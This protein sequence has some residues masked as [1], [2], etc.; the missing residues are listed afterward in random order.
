MPHSSPAA[1]P[2][3]SLSDQWA[4]TTSFRRLR[5][6]SWGCLSLFCLG[7]CGSVAGRH[8]APIRWA[9][10]ISLSLDL[11]SEGGRGG[12][13]RDNAQV[14]TTATTAH[15]VTQCPGTGMSSTTLCFWL[16]GGTTHAPHPDPERRDQGHRLP[17]A[18]TSH[19]S[20]RRESTVIP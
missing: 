19:K 18:A 16:E 4:E 7:P 9:G 8:G 6:K 11:R 13:L 5:R 3:L 12:T 10:V 1:F 2:S 20:A 17:R 15:A 14:L